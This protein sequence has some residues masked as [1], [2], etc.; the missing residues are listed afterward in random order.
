[1]N[2]IRN[3]GMRIFLIFELLLF[4]FQY[5]VFKSERSDYCYIGLADFFCFFSEV[6]S[7]SLL[8]FRGLTCDF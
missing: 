3:K 5:L 2:I 1:M 4:S 7:C 6:C 8:I